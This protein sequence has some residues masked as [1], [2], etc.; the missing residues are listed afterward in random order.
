M[1][2]AAADKFKF[3][4]FMFESVQGK[5]SKEQQQINAPYGPDNHHHTNSVSPDIAL[6]FSLSH[7]IPFTHSK[8]MSCQTIECQS[9]IPC[10]V[11]QKETILIHTIY[12]NVWTVLY[13][14][15]KGL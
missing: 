3:D 14:I 7:T 5:V 10:A 4:K 13:L 8:N 12:H 1:K 11:Y 2:G 6:L 15:K 9:T